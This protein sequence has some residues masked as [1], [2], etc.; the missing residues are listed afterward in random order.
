M[1]QQQ[2]FDVVSKGHNAFV[3]GKAGAGKTF[4]SHA[5]QELRARIFQVTFNQQHYIHSPAL[6]NA[7]VHL[8]RY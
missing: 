4:L 5:L 6:K 1:D 7:E 3:T 2:A 8:T